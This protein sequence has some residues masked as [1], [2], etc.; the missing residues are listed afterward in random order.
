MPDKEWIV[1]KQV[2]ALANLA[3]KQAETL[4]EYHRLLFGESGHLCLQ[5]PICKAIQAGE[6]FKKQHE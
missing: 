6:D 2:R 3:A 1:R 4:E 5:D